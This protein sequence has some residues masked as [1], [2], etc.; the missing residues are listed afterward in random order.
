[1]AY[2]RLREYLF[3]TLP[4][5]RQA[6]TRIKAPPYGEGPVF[7]RVPRAGPWWTGIKF[8]DTSFKGLE[9][10][11]RER[12]PWGVPEGRGACF[13]ARALLRLSY[14]PSGDDQS[15]CTAVL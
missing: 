9:G 5:F 10:A 11:V 7:R 6:R 14:Y 15:L 3:K 8:T 4:A 13:P 1:M 12:F 2:P